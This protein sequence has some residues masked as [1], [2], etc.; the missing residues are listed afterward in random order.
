MTA[1]LLM[2][3]ITG[4]ASAQTPAPTF[5]WKSATDYR[6]TWVGVD[7]ETVRIMDEGSWRADWT[8][9]GE[10]ADVTI[11]GVNWRKK[12]FDFQGTFEGAGSKGKVF[13]LALDGQPILW[14][15]TNESKGMVSQRLYPT[16]DVTTVVDKPKA[17]PSLWGAWIAPWW[18]LPGS[19]SFGQ[20]KQAY[21]WRFNEVRLTPEQTCEGTL[22]WNFGAPATTER[23]CEHAPG[24]PDF[25]RHEDGT[26]TWDGRIL[27]PAKDPPQHH[28]GKSDKLEGGATATGGN[29][30]KLDKTYSVEVPAG[31]TG[32]ITQ[33]RLILRSDELKVR[34]EFL[35]GPYVDGEGFQMAW[36][37]FGGSGPTS[38]LPGLDGIF[39]G[40][41]GGKFVYNV[42]L[43]NATS[44]FLVYTNASDAAL[45]EK[46]TRHISK[47]LQ[48]MP[49][50]Q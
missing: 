24:N 12:N 22:T 29:R 14:L 4:T 6:G 26:I 48:W 49:Q 5:N 32:E 31:W 42:P 46:I 18:D 10:R 19:V 2:A 34:L 3:L 38:R 7:G 50:A 13:L 9:K 30:V 39:A 15:E 40:V 21:G 47:T 44:V 43:D 36:E 23:S 35:P 20:I 17:E 11:S 28:A 37:Q 41:G 8:G 16:D 1:T 45:T 27:V 33:G 25:A